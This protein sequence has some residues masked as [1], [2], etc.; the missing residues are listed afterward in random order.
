MISQF[1]LRVRV[2]HLLGHALSGIYLEIWRISVLVSTLAGMLMIMGTFTDW[3]RNVT[4]GIIGPVAGF[5]GRLGLSPNRLTILGC[6][7]NIGVGVVVA[8]GRLQLGGFLLIVASAFD[9]IDG[10][11]ARQMGQ[12]TKF[13][14]FLDSVLDRVSESAILL[15]IAWWYLS[16]PGHIEEILAYMAIVGSLLVSYTRARAEGI[17]IEC[18]VGFLTRVE[19]A[20]VLIV[21]LILGL[22]P[23]GLGFLAVGTLVTT[24][25]RIVH[26][27][28]ASKEQLL[29]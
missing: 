3:L 5:F 7:L 17:A 6:L 19:R 23:W 16:Q 2:T 1:A 29:S 28:R 27:Y 4:K 12:T 10:T 13:G 15:G 22:V 8:T 14:A 26:V 11:L 18:K 24:V 9:A 20:I 25:W 21:A